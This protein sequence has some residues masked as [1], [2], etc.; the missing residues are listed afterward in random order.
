MHVPLNVKFQ[1]CNF[2]EL[3]TF[4]ML[5]F[6]QISGV[7]KQHSETWT[8][9][10][11]W[12]P[13]VTAIQIR[14][15]YSSV[16]AQIF[17]TILFF[18]TEFHWYIDRTWK[19]LWLTYKQDCSSLDFPRTV[20]LKIFCNRSWDYEKAPL[21]LLPHHPLLC[22]Y[23]SKTLRSSTISFTAESLATLRLTKGSQ[24]R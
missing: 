2:T 4:H 20:M 11:L 1:K 17:W 21:F 10:R 19:L 15:V 16:A 6:L 5:D 22:I 9:F 18:A 7:K 14:K 23:S 13:I 12:H 3:G 24:H 8:I